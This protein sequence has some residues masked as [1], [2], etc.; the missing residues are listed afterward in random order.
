MALISIPSIIIFP[1]PILNNLISKR[2]KVVL[3]APEEPTSAIFCPAGIVSEK[4]SNTFELLFSYMWVKLQNTASLFVGK[5][6]LP[7]FGGTKA[8]A[9]WVGL[10]MISYGV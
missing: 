3:P 6:L 7:K 10:S 4:L 2:T 9:T 8:T 1:E 5:P